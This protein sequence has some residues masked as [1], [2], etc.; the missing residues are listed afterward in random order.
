V[1]H[2]SRF[3]GPRAAGTPERRSV[4]VGEQGAPGDGDGRVVRAPE[5]P[6]FSAPWEAQAFAMAVALSE[7]GVF[8]WKE[9]AGRLADEIG[10]A[11]LRGEPDDGSRYYEH[12]LAALEKLV[13]DKGLV[14]TDEL[15]TRKAEW[16]Q[17]A[18]ETPH[19]RPIEL[20]RRGAA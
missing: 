6:L 8:T 10:S 3:P 13:G 12:W 17:A 2:E 5:A 4:A 9:W 16:D 20:R 19:G 11:R 1:T 7:R 18:R 14:L 15:R